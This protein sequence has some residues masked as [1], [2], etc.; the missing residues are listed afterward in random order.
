MS[1]QGQPL[2]AFVRERRALGVPWRRIT[3]DVNSRTGMDLNPD[4]LQRWFP[5]ED[6]AA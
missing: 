5:D 2:E 3:L 1:G 4:T 6:E